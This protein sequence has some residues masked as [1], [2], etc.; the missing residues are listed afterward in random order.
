MMRFLVSVSRLLARR[1]SIPTHAEGPGSDVEIAMIESLAS[2][3]ALGWY[4]VPF[5]LASQPALGW[6]QVPFCPVVAASV[7]LADLPGPASR[8]LRTS[9]GGL[10]LSG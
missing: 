2:Q 1:C 4:Q 7:G 3:P 9:C 10:D 6:Y 8:P 5:S